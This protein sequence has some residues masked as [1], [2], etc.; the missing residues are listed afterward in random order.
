MKLA[1]KVCVLTLL[2]SLVMGTAASSAQ[3]TNKR[4]LISPEELPSMQPAHFST[5][6]R[7]NWN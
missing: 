6:W 3:T 2:L 1:S 7:R 4:G 5:I